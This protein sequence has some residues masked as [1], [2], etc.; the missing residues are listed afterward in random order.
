MADHVRSLAEIRSPLSTNLLQEYVRHSLRYSQA[1]AKR[2]LLNAFETEEQNGVRR[3]LEANEVDI[4][5]E[6]GIA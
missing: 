5:E 1:Y 4:A 6:L 2:C 3:A